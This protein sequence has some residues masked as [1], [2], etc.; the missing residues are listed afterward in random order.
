MSRN[1]ELVT[2]E[3]LPEGPFD[4][5]IN[6]DMSLDEDS[7]HAME[8]ESVLEYPH[9][10]ACQVCVLHTEGS[11]TDAMQRP[12]EFPCTVTMPDGV[13]QLTITA[14]M[15]ENADKAINKCTMM[16]PTST[17]EELLTFNYFNW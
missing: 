3:L 4:C 7:E 5:R 15:A 16:L 8:V 6:S 17:L 9:K 14:E 11:A 2:K 12:T 13:R 10:I 1:N